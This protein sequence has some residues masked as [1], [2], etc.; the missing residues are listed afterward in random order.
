MENRVKKTRESLPIMCNS[1]ESKAVR[2]FLTRVGDKWSILVVVMLAKMPQNRA[3][4]SELQRMVDGIS[5]RM[6]TTTLRNLERDGFLSREVFPEVP[7]RVE[8]ALTDTGLTLLGPTQ[9]LVDWV[10]ANWN[11]VKKARERFDN[12]GGGT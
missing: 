6:L 10:G 9:H 3:R 2:D 7:P 12:R 5:Q 11:S 4:F 1:E 8:Y